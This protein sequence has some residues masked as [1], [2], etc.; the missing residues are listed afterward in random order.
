MRTVTIKNVFAPSQPLQLPVISVEDRIAGCNDEMHILSVK[1]KPCL[2][3][4]CDTEDEAIEF[5]HHNEDKI[6]MIQ[7]IWIGS[8]EEI[9][10]DCELSEISN[11]DVLE[12]AN[13]GEAFP[14]LEGNDLFDQNWTHEHD[15]DK[16]HSPVIMAALHQN[17]NLWSDQVQHDATEDSASEYPTAE[18]DGTTYTFLDDGNYEAWELEKAQDQLTDSIDNVECST[19]KS[20]I[21][22]NIDELVKDYANMPEFDAPY[23]TSFSYRGVS[24]QVLES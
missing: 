23:T 9:L 13:D 5:L 1:E 17:L 4:M 14:E 2:A 20:L 10:P 19:L 12:L 3:I 24:Y 8:E 21:M 16:D 22:R 18:I 11:D 6:P 7:G 15:A